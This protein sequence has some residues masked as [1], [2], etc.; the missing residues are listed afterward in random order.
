MKRSLVAGVLATSITGLGLVAAAPPAAAAAP[1]S[2]IGTATLTSSTDEPGRLAVSPDG[3]KIWAPSL[4]GGTTIDAFA[5]TTSPTVTRYST[6]TAAD[7][8]EVA[9][10]PDS[11]AAFVTSTSGNKVVRMN[12]STGAVVTTIPVG[13]APQGIAVG[14]TATGVRAYVV[15]TGSNSVSVIDTSSNTVVTTIPSVGT[16]PQVVALA[17]DGRTAYVGVSGGVAVVDT[18]TNTVTSTVSLANGSG[19]VVRDLVVAPD[20]KRFYAAHDDN[21]AGIYSEGWISAY[22]TA[23]LTHVASSNTSNG[24]PE[25]FTQIALTPDGKT[26]YGAVA[27]QTSTAAIW[28]YDTAA[29]TAPGTPVVEAGS[30]QAA[31]H[32]NFGIAASPTANL[33]YVTARQFPSYNMWAG[34]DVYSTPS[35]VPGAPRTPS[36]SSGSGS[37]TVSW[38]A[39][40]SNGG[41]AI[42]GYTVTA[43]PAARPAPPP[44]RSPAP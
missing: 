40:A 2:H 39:P 10:T 5:G 24:S 41:S 4:A 19:H 29:F 31:S 17:P 6:G 38:T 44:V 22:S 15:N 42:T 43:S 35:T 26:L 3:T 20:G 33:V 1:L 25:G 8:W 18:S 28:W 9:F 11:A 16:A 27:G 13:T 30:T 32:D 36:A 21:S 23:A 37:A 34:F 12:A 14:T 7:P